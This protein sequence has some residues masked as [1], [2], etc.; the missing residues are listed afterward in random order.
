LF[1]CENSDE[2]EQLDQR[3]RWML[4]VPLTIVSVGVG[5]SGRRMGQN[6]EPLAVLVDD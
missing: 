6:F 4:V 3:W 2:D 1:C 5:A